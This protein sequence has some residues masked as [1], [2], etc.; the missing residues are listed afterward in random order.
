M[1]MDLVRLCPLSPGIFVRANPMY[2]LYWFNVNWNF[3]PI[4]QVIIRP[5]S[6]RHRAV[7]RAVLTRSVTGLS[8]KGPGEGLGG[9]E[10]YA[11]RDLF[12]PHIGCSQQAW[13]PQCGRIPEGSQPPL[14][15]GQGPLLHGRGKTV[16]R[17]RGNP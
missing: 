13:P 10:S 2:N 14:E 3:R 12:F 8:A 1:K 11:R 9:V 6:P 17:V 7:F 5:L 15:P 4:E 16:S